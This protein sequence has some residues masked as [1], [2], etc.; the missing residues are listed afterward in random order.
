MAGVRVV[1]GAG[2]SGRR[3]GLGIW[4]RGAG[5]SQLEGQLVF[6][7]LRVRWGPSRG[8]PL[9]QQGGL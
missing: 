6:L 7:N 1:G 9:S 2:R 8:L 5:S 3:W 4:L